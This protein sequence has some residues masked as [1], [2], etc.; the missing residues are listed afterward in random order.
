[1]N[2]VRICS[3]HPINEGY[4]SH[5][6]YQYSWNFVGIILLDLHFS[7]QTG[8]FALSIVLTA[9]W[10]ELAQPLII[11]QANVRDYSLIYSIAR[12]NDLT[13]V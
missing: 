7:H 4:A 11:L 6:L 13:E 3:G 8:Q 5:K 12:I 9:S 2:W 10:T 1:M